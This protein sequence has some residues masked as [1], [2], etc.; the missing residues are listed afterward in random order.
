MMDKS[1]HGRNSTVN[2]SRSQEKE[3]QQEL[4]NHNSDAKGNNAS[5]TEKRRKSGSSPIPEVDEEKA[6]EKTQKKKLKRKKI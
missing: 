5:L 6:I 4:Q 1:A 3:A 2:E